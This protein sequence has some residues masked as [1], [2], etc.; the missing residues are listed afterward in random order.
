MT[1]SMISSPNKHNRLARHFPAALMAL[2]LASLGIRA[3]YCADTDLARSTE[4]PAS[5]MP[6]GQELDSIAGTRQSANG[7][8]VVQLGNKNDVSITQ[9]SDTNL[10]Q[11]LQSGNLNQAIMQ[12]SAGAPPAKIGQYGS[13]TFAKLIQY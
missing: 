6:T 11:I 5:E 2:A 9:N 12:Q 8:Y 7:A 4:L 10:A 1:H 3:G 13:G